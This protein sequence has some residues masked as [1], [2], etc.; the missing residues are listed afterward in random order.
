[1]EVVLVVNLEDGE[2]SICVWLLLLGAKMSIK[3]S[4]CAY[5]RGD[6]PGKNYSVR[7][8]LATLACWSGRKVG[9]LPH[10]PALHKRLRYQM[11]LIK[12]FFACWGFKFDRCVKVSVRCCWGKYLILQLIIWPWVPFVRWGERKAWNYMDSKCLSTVKFWDYRVA[13]R[14]L[15]SSSIVFKL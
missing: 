2:R 7:S 14:R 4:F 5:K 9:K 10:K 6:V 13:K 15:P 1:M 12:V 3:S 11:Q 8:Q